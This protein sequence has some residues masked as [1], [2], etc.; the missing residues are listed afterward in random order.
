MCSEREKWATY[1]KNSHNKFQLIDEDYHVYTRHGGENGPGKK[2]YW[3]CDHPRCS[4]MAIVQDDKI[5]RTPDHSHQSNKLKL[6]ARLCELRA[7]ER[8]GEDLSIKPS[9]IIDELRK[10]PDNVRAFLKSDTSIHRRI[11]RRR[12]AVRKAAE[13][14]LQTQPN[15]W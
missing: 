11:R 7:V 13:A 6:E 5:I 1:F 8:A 4:S 10:V 3:L 12:A 2:T 9:Q 14:A 15:L